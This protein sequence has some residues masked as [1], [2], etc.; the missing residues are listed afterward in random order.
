MSLD[1]PRPPAGEQPN[2][3]LPAGPPEPQ[4]FEEFDGV[5]TTTSRPGVEDKQ[6]WWCD[7][8]MPIGR[9]FLRTMYGVGDSIY[10]AGSPIAFFDFANIGSTPYMV[11][12]LNNG[13]VEMVNTATG[14]VSSVAAAGTI[15][16]P[17][18][19]TVGVSQFGSTYIIIVAQQTNGYFL[20]DGT[21]FYKAGGVAPAPSITAGGSG[22]TSAPTVS[23]SG[24][25]G[26]GAAGTAV[27]TNG[28][29]TSIQI[30]NPG[31]GYTGAPTISISGG[32]GSGATATATLSPSAVGG[33]AVETYQGRVW[34][35]NG[36]T[37]TF[38]AP[39][40]AKDFS[41]AN[42]GGNF[43]ST[44]SFLR[45]RFT[46]LKQTNGFLYL[47]GDS[48]VNYISGVQT[49]GSPPVTTFTNQNADPEV[50]T[51]WGATP[52]VFSRNIVFANSFGVHVNYGAAVTK[53]S[54]PMD[55]VYSTVANFGSFLP[56]A[57]KAIIFG[58]KVFLLLLPIV[59]PVSG[60]QVNKLLMWEGKRWWTSEQD[61]PL[62]YI[63][64]QEI[65]S[66]LT[67][68]GTDG[69]R[70]YPLF[71]Q[72]SIGFTKTVQSKL[73]DKPGSYN[74]TKATTRL[75]G[76]FR[77]YSPAEAALRI[78]IDNE[79]S[80]S[81]VASDLGPLDAQW[82]TSTGA[83][84]TWH[85]EGGA[86]ATWTTSGEGVVVLEP[87]EVGQNGALTGLTVQT[88]AADMAIISMMI[89]NE[90]IAYRG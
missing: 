64:F 19:A 34:V 63:N 42:G 20:W 23:F 41:S 79:I 87:T 44:D 73:W 88:E 13:A 16:N 66:V 6:M 29:V 38:S 18:R 14:A 86:D 77:Y 51:P 57:A 84:A 24:G 71:Q 53:I 75:W 82:F 15:T 22:Y 33:T 81:L 36:P 26:S 5:Y 76:M 40:S 10:N 59:D 61:V 90:V 39:G 78:S 17:S 12:V 1:K 68:Y 89:Q 25:G 65:N 72:P 11:V 7:G 54:E 70:I 30:T 60:Q 55:G 56:S 80:R 28:V 2:P 4:I 43:T 48:S 45:A 83:L 69:T 8:F 74:I 37:I 46:A 47:I 35:A 62:S 50:G 3:Y 31:T 27:V 58:K 52:L 32:G 21:T 9:R 67:A 49:S 85:T